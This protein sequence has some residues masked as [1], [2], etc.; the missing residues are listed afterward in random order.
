MEIDPDMMLSAEALRQQAIDIWKNEFHADVGRL[1]NDPETIFPYYYHANISLWL[2]RI[3][4]ERHY[5]EEAFIDG[6]AIP[7]RIADSEMEQKV[8]YPTVLAAWLTTDDWRAHQEN[9]EVP[10]D[11]SYGLYLNYPIPILAGANQFLNPDSETAYDLDRATLEE[12]KNLAIA[13]VRK[14][15]PRDIQHRL[16]NIVPPTLE[17]I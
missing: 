14:H 16:N 5:G 15:C 7:E 10:E 9:K 12:C 3:L 1:D 6:K 4:T 13:K 8:L 17:A 11:L 2:I